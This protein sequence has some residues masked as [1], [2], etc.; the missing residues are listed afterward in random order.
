MCACAVRAC[1]CQY[2]CVRARCVRGACA[3]VCVHLSERAYEGYLD[4]FIGIALVFVGVF[5]VLIYAYIL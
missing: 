4:I 2:A 3:R 1:V 5:R